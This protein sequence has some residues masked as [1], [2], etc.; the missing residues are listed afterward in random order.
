MDIGAASAVNLYTFQNTA[1]SRGQSAAVLQALTQF[2][3]EST[4]AAGSDPMG[5][6]LTAASLAPVANAMSALANADAEANGSA[7]AIPLEALQGFLSYGGLNAASAATLFST[8]FE[9]SGSSSQ[10]GFDSALTATSTLALA[11]YQ[12]SLAFAPETATPTQTEQATQDARRSA[13]A[14]IMNLLG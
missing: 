7:G 5:S 8:S 1:S 11:A 2:Y 10:T 6:L 4:A 13:T 14:S 9:S 3:T 12:A